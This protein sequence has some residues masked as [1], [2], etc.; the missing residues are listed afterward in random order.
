MKQEDGK[1][2]WIVAENDEAWQATQAQTQL[3]GD[4]PT[5]LA[6]NSLHKKEVVLTTLL[7]TLLL[8][9][10]GGWLWPRSILTKG[11][12]Q[13][14]SPTVAQA[15]QALTQTIESLD[16]S[17]HVNNIQLLGDRVMAQVT[18]V[19]TEEG[20]VRAYRE[21][22]FYGK[23]AAGWQR[24]PPDLALLGPQKTLKIANFTILYDAVDADAIYQAAPKIEQLFAGLRHDFG[25]SAAE[26]GS[27]YTIEIAS[28]SI[29]GISFYDPIQRKLTIASPLLLSVPVEITPAT[30]VEQVTVY[31]LARL[32]IHEAIN[33]HDE[34]WQYNFGHWYPMENSLALWALWQEG[35][36]IVSSHDA[37]ITWLYQMSKNPSSRH[38]L[39]AGYAELCHFDRVWQ[40]IPSDL[41]IPLF[42][43]VEAPTGRPAN[44]DLALASRWPQLVNYR[45]EGSYSLPRPDSAAISLETIIE[46]I[47][48][49]YGR[50]KLPQFF[51]ALGEHTTPDT[52]IPALFGVSRTSFEAGWQGLSRPALLGALAQESITRF[53]CHG[54]QQLA[55]LSQFRFDARKFLFERGCG[56]WC[57]RLLP[58][59][60]IVRGRANQQARH[61]A[62]KHTDQT[63]T[64]NHEENGGDTSSCGDGIVVAI[65]D[66]GDR[67]HRIPD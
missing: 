8:L 42:C 50:D 21:T 20:K 64:R 55:E 19:D 56:F 33:Q 15:E 11:T 31:P 23:S 13:K 3:A 36:P 53:P 18:V 61:Q 17:I 54:F 2:N 7:A 46:Y 49:T 38:A 16:T 37:L 40:L 1:F 48:A 52:L 28:S 41:M 45:G 47:V 10:I 57:R 51:N 4:P 25:L 65:A 66:G 27:P 34:R 32:L 26:A 12:I 39:P 59:I 5:G 35:G 44:Y 58:M 30:L 14:L 43:N 60:F 9:M 22:H 6:I 67:H 29:L 62:G 63:E 24:I